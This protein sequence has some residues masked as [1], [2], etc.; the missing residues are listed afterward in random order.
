[1][2]WLRSLAP[3]VLQHSMALVY[4]ALAV[5]FLGQMARFHDAQT[6]FTSLEIFGDY[7]APYRTARV[8][9]LPLYTYRDSTGYDGQFYAQIAAA[10]TPFDPDLRTA[11]DSPAYRTGRVLIPVLAHLAGLGRPAWAVAAYALSNVVC[12]VILAWVTA[13][14]WF[15]PSDM[16]NLL[17]W[18]GTLFGAGMLTTVTHCLTD[19][20]TLLLIAC[21]VRC[22]EVNRRWLAAAA[23]GAAGLARETSVLAVTTLVP[24]WRLRRLPLADLA[25]CGACVLPIVL[26]QVALSAHYGG[27]SKGGLGAIGAP[28]AGWIY[29]CE[30]VFAVTRERGFLAAADEFYVLVAV[31]VQVGFVLFRPRPRDVWWR[32]GA[33]FAVLAVLIGP[34]SW[35]DAIT[36]VPR[37]LLPLTLAFNVLVPRSRQGVALLLAGNMTLLSAPD[38]LQGPIPTEQTTFFDGI[39]CDYKSGWYDAEH[40]GRRTWRWASA[41]ATMIFHNPL[42]EVRQISIDFELTSPAARTVTISTTDTTRT[43]A[44][45]QN[46]RVRIHFGPLRLSPGDTL[47]AFDTP[48]APWTPPV[49]PGRGLTFSVQ[50][51]RVVSDP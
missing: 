40:L 6:G 5:S 16:D 44:L 20:P 37:T 24:S 47:L 10:R 18:V 49:A 46:H 38:L 19:G 45:Q 8:R 39:T 1:M 11:L 14:W 42:A 30:D 41:S 33:G 4:V 25:S 29:K 35:R 26:W 34:A 23:L 15:P 28:F 9:S 51:L 17:R 50:N 3:W 31:L 22:I 48:E 7:F 43:F 12:W 2:R 13:R 21:G 36:G 27:I 32:L